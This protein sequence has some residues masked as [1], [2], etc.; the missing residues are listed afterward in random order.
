MA[1]IWRHTE[2]W[3]KEDYERDRR[4]VEERAMAEGAKDVFVNGD[5]L[6]PDAR[7]LEATF[8]KLM[9]AGSAAERV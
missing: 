4:F 6:I 7:P 5:A 3:N 8:E 9:L 2:G 1:V